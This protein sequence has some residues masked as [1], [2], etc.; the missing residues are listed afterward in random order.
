MIQGEERE[1]GEDE[2]AAPFLKHIAHEGNQINTLEKLGK[3]SK[4]SF[5]FY[6]VGG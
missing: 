2:V 5:I 1:R 4:W 3:G 6:T